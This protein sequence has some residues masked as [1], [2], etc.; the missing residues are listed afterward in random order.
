MEPWILRLP[1]AAPDAWERAAA[2]D[3]AWFEAN[4][5]RRTRLRRA[6]FGE[7]PAHPDF[8]SYV[9]VREVS[10]GFRIRAH[11]A[12]TGALN[13]A[14]A[15]EEVAVWFLHRFAPDVLRIEAEHGAKTKGGTDV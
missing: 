13:R 2:D 10:P 4:P 12:T 1:D 14:E 6:V 3:R 5:G 9:I 15:P 8:L 7:F 11:F